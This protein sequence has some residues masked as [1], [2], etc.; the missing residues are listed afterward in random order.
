MSQQGFHVK[1]GAE[2][3]ELGTRRVL[4]RS[5]ERDHERTL[6]HVWEPSE[7]RSY[8]IQIQ[9]FKRRFEL[10]RSR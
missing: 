6:V 7:G 1:V 10:V 3:E 2:Y 8:N 9:S 5:V 4:V